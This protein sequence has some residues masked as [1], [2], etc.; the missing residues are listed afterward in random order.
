ML[1]ALV[2]N[3]NFIR[4]FVVHTPSGPGGWFKKMSSLAC[5]N[6]GQ[7]V[8]KCIKVSG[9]SSHNLHSVAIGRPIVFWCF[10]K[11]LCPV[12]ALMII[13]KYAL[14]SINVCLDLLT[15]TCLLYTSPSPRD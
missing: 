4:F 8:H 15:S 10:A 14:D 9:S 11:K 7:A 13:C 3:I 6:T 5:L 2:C 12:M 1:Y